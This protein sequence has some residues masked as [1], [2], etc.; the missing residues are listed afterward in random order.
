MPERPDYAALTRGQIAVLDRI[1]AGEAGL[2]VLQ[3]IVRLAQDALG[4]RGAGFAEYAPGHGRI[5]AATGACER[6][7][8]AGSTGRTTGCATGAPCWSRSTR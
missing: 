4:G 5:I 7:S 3:R 8:A 2:P 6:A 1:N